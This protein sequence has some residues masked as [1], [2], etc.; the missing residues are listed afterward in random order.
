MDH[1]KVS[2]QITTKRGKSQDLALH[3]RIEL[4]AKTSPDVGSKLLAI[5][6]IGN[7]GSHSDQLQS[8]D[9]LDVFDLLSYAF[10]EIFEKNQSY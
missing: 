5:K 9:I 2:K 6:W 1:M 3:A 10:G 7:S 4:F 8:E